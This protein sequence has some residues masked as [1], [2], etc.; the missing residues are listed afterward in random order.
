M[1]P[2]LNKSVVVSWFLRF[3]TSVFCKICHLLSHSTFFRLTASR[4]LLPFPF[5]ECFTERGIR[6]CYSFIL[7]PLSETPFKLSLTIN[8]RVLLRSLSNP[9]SNVTFWV[10]RA[11]QVV[12][13]LSSNP[14]HPLPNWL[15]SSIP[16]H[17]N[18]RKNHVYF[19]NL[20]KAYDYSSLFT[21]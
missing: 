15:L 2:I 9:D 5:A 13:S 17:Q 1:W 14:L 16:M 18:A 20:S 19:R 12:W 8:I 6:E 11:H 3:I 10:N 7:I 21:G 4:S